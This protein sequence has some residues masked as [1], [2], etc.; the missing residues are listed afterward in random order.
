MARNYKARSLTASTNE[1]TLDLGTE[2]F[3]HITNDSLVGDV[4]IGLEESTSTEVDL[5]VIKPGE[6]V[7]NFY[8]NTKTLYYKSSAGSVNFRFL[9]L[10][11]AI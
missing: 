9:A 10:N 8:H 7:K 6:S 11:T 1:A 2:V 4:I 3:L 5:I